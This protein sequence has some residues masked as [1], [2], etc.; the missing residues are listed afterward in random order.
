MSAYDEV[1]LRAQVNIAIFMEFSGDSSVNPDAAV[2]VLEQLWFD[3]E[4]MPQIE[5]VRLKGELA[6]IALEYR[7]KKIAAFIRN[8]TDGQLEDY[9]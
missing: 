7:D 9:F 2:G 4:K 1:L 8:L 6:T 3:L 5:K